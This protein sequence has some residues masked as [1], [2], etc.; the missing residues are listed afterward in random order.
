[1]GQLERGLP[2]AWQVLRDGGTLA[3]I[4]FHS[5]EDRM[6]KRFF[7]ARARGC[8]CPPELPV[9]T[10]GHQPEARLVNRRAI[11]PSAS[12][13]QSNPRASSARLRGA[14]KREAPSAEGGS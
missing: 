4:S 7:S 14:R 3:A 11:V 5:L 9:C 13:V 8:I 6:V 10:C 2:L 1:R 12:E